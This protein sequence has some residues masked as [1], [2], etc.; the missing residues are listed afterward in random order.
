MTT[1]NLTPA[2]DLARQVG[3]APPNTRFQLAPGHYAVEQLVVSRDAKLIGVEAAQTVLEIRQCIG[4]ERGALTLIGL[5]LR[6]GRGD[7]GGAVEV[8]NASR[9]IVDFCVFSRNEATRIGGAIH[10][11]P[12]RATISRSLFTENRAPAGG[13]LSIHGCSNTVVDSCFF[14]GNE[15]QVGGAVMVNETAKVL[16]KSCTFAR[17]R[18]TFE[19]DEEERE[20]GFSAGTALAVMGAVGRGPEVEL[21][22][23]LF[24]DQRPLSNHPFTPGRLDLSSCLLPPGSLDRLR[25]RNN[26]RSLAVEVLWT[27]VDG[28]PGL[29]PDSPGR[30]MADITEIAD[31]A[32]DLL[33]RPL[34]VRGEADP[35]ALGP[36]QPEG[37][38][39]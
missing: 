36:V 34:V 26:G 17:N 13:A 14:S 18:A 10:L 38:S 39:R 16:V 25:H 32:V 37:A 22:N 30:R 27:E 28:L 2:D 8:V 5:T 33:G 3:L 15:A 1:V 6:G 35:G 29:A 31:G 19:P 24:G 21:V 20:A 7:L 4:V 23:C 12:G 9:L 11:G